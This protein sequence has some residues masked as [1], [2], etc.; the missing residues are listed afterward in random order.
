MTLYEQYF[1]NST[2]EFKKQLQK[3]I[4]KKIKVVLPFLPPKK[5]I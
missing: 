4:H 5:E 2:P 3:N 1:K